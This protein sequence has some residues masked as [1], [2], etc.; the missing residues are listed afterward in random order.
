MDWMK[1]LSERIA[2][3]VKTDRNMINAT[4]KIASVKIESAD[5]LPARL[6]ILA[7]TT[8]LFD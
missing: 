4:R 5:A 8:S 7:N 1:C 2:K 6:F 3:I